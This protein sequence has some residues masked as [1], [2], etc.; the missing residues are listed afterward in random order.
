MDA[1]PLGKSGASPPTA[2]HPA[3]RALHSVGATCHD[4]DMLST[5]A[6]ANYRSL[7][8]LIV[9]LSGLDIVTGENGSGKSSL[10]RALRLLASTAD[11]GIVGGLAREGGL[12]STLW[13]GPESISRAMRAGEVAVQGTRRSRPIELMLGFACA[14]ERAGSGTATNPDLSYLID[15]GLPQRDGRTMFG[16]DPEIKREQI[17]SGPVA[18]P[19]AVLV[20]RTRAALRVRDGSWRTVNRTF[21]PTESILS[22]FVGADDAPEVLGVRRNVRGWRFYDHFRTDPEAP[23]RHPQLGTR[24]PVLDHGGVSFAA[25]VQTIIE[26]GHEPRLQAEIER[27]FPGSRIAVRDEGGLFRAELRQP[28]MLRPL[29]MAEVSDGTLRY[30][31]LIAALLSPRPPKLLV[32]NEP[33][34]SLHVD[35]L[36][37]LAELILQARA[38]TQIIVV[39]HAAPLVDAL[40]AGGATERRLVKDHGETT[41]HGQGFMDEPAW[42]WGSR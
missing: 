5:V 36:P 1:S 3:S 28:G 17:F 14:P 30:L 15:L 25:A 26:D 22:E 16:Q 19:G 27:A 23:A 33:E 7:R 11:G 38:D 12:S 9:P 39:S 35:L 13:A 32:L 34:T 31:L 21:S 2:P 24:T 10:Y 18:R 6:V 40:K 41:L 37:R 8:S 42:S 29:G 20:D 4:F